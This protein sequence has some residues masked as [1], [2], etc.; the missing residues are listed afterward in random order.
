MSKPAKPAKPAS[1]A[2][3]IIGVPMDLGAARRGV[4]MGPS[5]VRVT[6]FYDR[7]R[8][9]GYAV[10]D[11]GDI[12][13]PI[14]EACEIG[15]E[16]KK[17]SAAIARVCERLADVVG[18]NLAAGRVP[19]VLG[20][21]HSIAM[22]SVGGAARHFAAAGA[23]PLG[24]IWFDAHGDMNDPGSSPSGNVHG[25]SLAHVLGLGDPELA[26]IAGVTG[27]VPV[28]KTCLIG[29]RDIDPGER[30]IIAGAGVRVFTMK[31]IDRFGAA[32]VFEQAVEIASEGTAGVHVSYDIDVVD[33]SFA[34]GVGTAERGGLNYR[35]AH[36]FMELVADRGV[37]RSLDMVEV[38][39]IFVNYKTT[40]EL[41]GGLILSAL[42]KRII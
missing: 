41:A 17:Y 11:C 9:L 3:A 14:P 10:T 33:P 19:V 12:E 21:D 8:A 25:M 5:A 30:G 22:G 24:L 26:G 16:H 38:N 42:G 36:L 27:K 29:T 18:E 1:K 2:A 35:E 32:K 31:E 15:D 39:P 23:G 20:G 7:L 28:A 6:R 13:V 4:D 40:A 34:P 37:L